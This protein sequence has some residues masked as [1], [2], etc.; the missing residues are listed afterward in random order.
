MDSLPNQRTEPL[1]ESEPPPA[2][3]PGPGFRPSRRQLGQAALLGLASWGGLEVHARA[4]REDQATLP[5]GEGGWDAFTQV[6]GVVV[7]CGGTG[8]V[9]GTDRFAAELDVLAELGCNWIQIHPY[10]GINSEGL[11]WNRLDPA[12]PPE[13]LTRPIREAHA[14][15]LKVLIKPHLAYWGSGFSWRGEIEF[16]GERAERFWQSYGD[17]IEAVAQVTHGA[18]AF[19]VGTELDRML[20]ARRWRAVVERVRAV[21]PGH[22]TYAANWT[23]VERVDFWDSLDCIGVQAYYPLSGSARPDDGEL[24]RSWR[25]YVARLERLHLRTGKPVVFSELGYSAGPLAAKEPWQASVARSEDPEGPA[26]VR[27]AE[28]LQLRCYRAAFDVLQANREWL[29]GAF[30][31]KWFAGGARSRDFRLQADHLTPFLRERF[32]PGPEDSSALVDPGR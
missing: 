6:K 14:R 21:H 16:S 18:D 20:S 27:A 17:W 11:V 24:A 2:S 15:N 26:G 23:D 5:E 10:A 32:A 7:S 4:R 3:P 8:Q 13:Q 22:L 28:A 12:N 29:R 1:G 9:W 19:C 30:L 25:K 31:W